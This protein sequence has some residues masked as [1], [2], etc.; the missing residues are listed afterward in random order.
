MQSASTRIRAGL[1][2]WLLFKLGKDGHPLDLFEGST[3]RFGCRSWVVEDTCGS[4]EELIAFM[5][6]NSS[7]SVG[8]QNHG[9]EK[10]DLS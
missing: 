4:N 10:P 6:Y 9:L 2:G 8:F 5:I 3:H 1:H 7:I